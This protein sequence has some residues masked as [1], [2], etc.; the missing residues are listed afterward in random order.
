MEARMTEWLVKLG[1]SVQALR[2]LV[3]DFHSS[4]WNVAEDNGSYYLTSDSFAQHDD[5][6]KVADA[7]TLFLRAF[8]GAANLVLGKSPEVTVEATYRRNPEGALEKVPQSVIFH[9]GLYRP[10]MQKSIQEV[11]ELSLR[12]ADVAEAL[13][14]Y[15]YQHYRWYN[16]YKVYEVICRGVGGMYALKDKNWADKDVVSRFTF[17]CQDANA[18]GDA[19]RHAK[20]SMPGAQRSEQGN[21]PPDWLDIAEA[22][23]LITDLLGKWIDSLDQESRVGSALTL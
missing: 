18:I 21:P 20:G 16:L 15:S 19:S 1:G 9:M 11:V 3:S 10:L 14:Y 6:N 8:N 7:T 2:A 12:R 23:T 13:R 22:E 17:T 4:S 5:V